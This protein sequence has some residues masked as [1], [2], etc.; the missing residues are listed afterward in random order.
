MWHGW[1]QPLGFQYERIESVGFDREWN[2][3]WEECRK[4]EEDPSLTPR[5]VKV[6][7]T[8]YRKGTAVQSAIE[9][10]RGFMP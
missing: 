6:V 5:L 9:R 8:E 7:R 10:I 2:S 3:G 4:L 1:H